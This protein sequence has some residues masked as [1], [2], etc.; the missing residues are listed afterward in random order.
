[1]KA[2]PY[3]QRLVPIAGVVL[4]RLCYPRLW[5]GLRVEINSEGRVSYGSGVR[6][7]EGT[8]I[9]VFAA[10]ILS[11][12]D[13]IQVSRSAYLWVDSGAKLSI[14]SGTHIQDHCRLYGNVA[15]GKGCLFAPNVFSPRLPQP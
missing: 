2:S 7:G 5:T 11:I 15:I 9:D 8:R 13:G 1:M 4:N 14:G 10:G 6:L 12:D 3:M